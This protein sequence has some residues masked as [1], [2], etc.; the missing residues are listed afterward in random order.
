MPKKKTGQSRGRPTKE[1]SPFGEKP[2]LTDKQWRGLEREFLAIKDKFQS[3]GWPSLAKLHAVATAADVTER[4]VRQWRDDPEYLRGLWWLTAERL[5]AKMAADDPKEPNSKLTGQQH[6]AL[7]HAFVKNNWTGSAQSPIDQKVY[8]SVGD[9]VAH[10]IA[11]GDS[12]GP[13][14]AHDIVPWLGELVKKKSE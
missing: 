8:L 12:R 10:L 14:L 7:L 1:P 6:A 9:Y 4:A 3:D 11:A 13:A 2:N 5:T